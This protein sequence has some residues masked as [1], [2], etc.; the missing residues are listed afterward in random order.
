MKLKS[1]QNPK[2]GYCYVENDEGELLFQLY[3]DGG[4]EMKLQLQRLDKSEC[5]VHATWEFTIVEASE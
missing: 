4:G 1:V 3:F 5:K 2:P